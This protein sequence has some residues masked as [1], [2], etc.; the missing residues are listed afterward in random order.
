[1]EEIIAD[2]EEFEGK[3]LYDY[4]MV[5]YS[6]S[7]NQRDY[8]IHHFRDY[9]WE[10]GLSIAYCIVTPMPK[11]GFL[12]SFQKNEADIEFHFKSS[13]RFENKS[14]EEWTETDLDEALDTRLLG[15]DQFFS[16]MFYSDQSLEEKN[17]VFFDQKNKEYQV[18]L[19]KDS[20]LSEKA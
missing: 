4:R 16:N 5:F 18:N 13:K 11:V 8:L 12:K 14:W 6:I 10:E 17:I 1:V 15:E 19:S 3:K 7:K 2:L 20:D 9:A